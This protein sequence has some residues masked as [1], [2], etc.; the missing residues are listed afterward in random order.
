LSASD[1][2][3]PGR[4]RAAGIACALG[5][6]LLAA[7]LLAPSLL[8]RTAFVPADYWV[9]AIPF[10]FDPPPGLREFRSNALLGD[11]AILYPPQLW[12]LRN[13]L[14]EGELA[15]WNRWVRGGEAMLGSGQAG[16][17][18]PTTWPIL[19]LPWPV[20]F[21][22]SAWLRFGLLWLGAYRFGRALGL[23]RAGSVAVAAGFCC[24]PLFAVHFQ[25]LPRATAHVALPWLLLAVERLAARAGAST[26]A[27]VRAA[28][29][30]APWAA[31][32][33]WAGYAPAA[34]TVLFGAGLYAAI[35]LPWRPPARAVANRAWVGLA[36]LLG[37]ALALPVLLPFAD[38]L[39]ESGTLADRGEGG[40]WTLPANALR[41]L[42]DPFAFGSPFVRTPQPWNGPENFEEA[43]QY[44][45][46]V[47]WILLLASLPALRRLDR[48]ERLRAAGLAALVAVA[49]SLAFGAW[50]LHPLLTLVPPFSVNSNPR[51]LFLAQTGLGVLALLLASRAFAVARPARGAFAPVA[52][53]AAALGVALV[54]L[55]SPDPAPARPWV[56][57][58][59]AV[60][61]VASLAL[62]STPRERRIAAAL[63]PA[64]WL[65]DA[66][67]VYARLHPQP[68][69]DWADPA[70]AVAAL[71]DPLRTE[72]SPRVAF[73]RVTPPN[74]PALFG[75]EDVR[76]Y[77][78]P[79]P[80]RYDRYGLDVMGVA[81]PLNLL[82][83]DLVAASVI[84]GLERTCA[85]W[86][87]TTVRYDG[88]PLAAR[89]E[90][91]WDRNGR[92]FV[93]RL[94]RASPCAAW[95]AADAVSR[96]ADLDEAVVA[97]RDSLA[98]DDEAIFVEAA[99]IATGAAR[100]EP[101][102]T[103]LRWT[104]AN[105]LEV[106]VPEAARGRDGWLVL[107]VSHD[108]G[109]SARSETGAA[110]RVAPAQVRFLAVETPAGTER[111]SLAYAPKH[112]GVAWAGA[113]AALAV[114][115]LSA[116]ATRP[117]AT[118]AP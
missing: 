95:Y 101:A 35:R 50:P 80:L 85:P 40:Q 99:P 116:A 24:A 106:V 112:W 26:A 32:A 4:A 70:R 75:V 109:W 34:L 76:A 93:H 69:A 71:P 83:E 110:L 22:W 7:L 60:A 65:A 21:A 82:R 108:A 49:A 58:V 56:A 44:V 16:P 92:V 91:V 52:A 115:A 103:E 89:L 84:A 102:P 79:T 86:L 38:A 25:Q 107:R 27:R 57:L 55:A 18:A 66:G 8:G 100:P 14:A 30:L 54:V 9:G 104:G 53:I 61:L 105:A 98:A 37:V 20:G 64:L 96:V 45:G 39:R 48:D 17:F 2:T 13:A 5:G 111:V 81:M 10:A 42:F 72:A 15:L 19:L 31:F 62:A 11:P 36:L 33:C 63:V 67:A 43:Q 114:L 90:R 3:V 74:L 94:L 28:L 118:R 47:P 68:P 23:A 77:S 113:G 97:L 12:V 46:L 73:E 51:L 59:A 117:R 29:P 78:F 41:M 1:A 88:T 87:L 6:F